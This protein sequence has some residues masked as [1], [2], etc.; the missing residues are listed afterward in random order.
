M[1]L[2]NIIEDIIG[3]ILQSYYIYNIKVIK[4]PR[5]ERYSFVRAYYYSLWIK[6]SVK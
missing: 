5:R 6:L 1:L 3:C 4:Y 2:N